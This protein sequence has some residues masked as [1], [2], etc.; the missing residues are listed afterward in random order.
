MRRYLFALCIGLF[1]AIGSFSAYAKPSLT[2]PH[3]A[4]LGIPTL[5]SKSEIPRLTLA[6][7]GALGVSHQAQTVPTNP[8]TPIPAFDQTYLYFTI[9]ML[10][11]SLVVGV[12]E[13]I[14]RQVGGDPLGWQIAGV[15]L[16]GAG[17][18]YNAVIMSQMLSQIQ[19]P[20]IQ[21]LFWASL[22]ASGVGFL[23]S[24]VQLII[25]IHRRMS[26][27]KEIPKPIALVPWGDIDERGNPRA[28]LALVGHF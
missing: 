28:G 24:V 22:I 9:G 26:K 14:T 4:N 2:L 27:P 17:T 18:V 13:T 19:E 21:A 8:Q 5:Y 10:A 6:Y 12:G 25:Q 3:A 23:V 7:H 20:M 15:L 1:V 16:N 11:G